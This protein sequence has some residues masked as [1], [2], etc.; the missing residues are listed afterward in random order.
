[1]A[2]AP[3]RRSVVVLWWAANSRLT[4][5]QA[6]AVGRCDGSQTSRGERQTIAKAKQLKM[7][8]IHTRRRAG[9]CLVTFASKVAP[10]ICLQC[11]ISKANVAVF[12]P[13]S[14]PQR[15]VAMTVALNM[16]R[17]VAVA[18]STPRSLLVTLQGLFVVARRFA[19]QIC[20]KNLMRQQMRR[21]M[22]RISNEARSVARLQTSGSARAIN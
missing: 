18:F 17:N 22:P 2:A 16:T 21:L 10:M 1:M 5:H 3:P 7:N 19:V 15:A 4:T 6:L 8:S 12:G 20:Q 11:A 13:R 9:A 14:A